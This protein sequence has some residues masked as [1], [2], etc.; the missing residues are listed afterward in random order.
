MSRII[1]TSAGG[2][3][4][5]NVVQSLKLAEPT[6]IVG[7][8][9][10][11]AMLL[12]S[13]ADEKAVVHHASEANNF[14][15]SEMNFLA[16]KHGC[17]MLIPVSDREIYITAINKK[18]L[19]PTSIPNLNIVK[20]CRNKAE[21]FK[22]M[23]QHGLPTP[24]TIA[25]FSPTHYPASLRDLNGSFWMRATVGSGGYLAHKIGNFQDIKA[26]L[27][28]YRNKK[29]EF[30]LTPYLDGQNFCWTSLW[31]DGELKLSVTK[32]RLQWVY[33]K[34]GTT[35]VQ[36]TVHNLQVS[37]LCQ[38][39]V[40]ALIDTYE[41]D[42]TGLMMADLKQDLGT[43]KI[44][45]TEIN[46]GRTGTVSLWFTLASHLIY[47]DHRVNFHHQLLRAHHKRPVLPCKKN[48][49][50]PENIMFIRHI[51]MG[52]LLMFE[53]QQIR[54]LPVPYTSKHEPFETTPIAVKEVI[55]K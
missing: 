25:P 39:T 30:M 27:H 43:G 29:R 15:I 20:L 24:F 49:S 41:P 51:D 9:V 13:G 55:G 3:A 38:D 14:Y 33:D 26:L 53:N 23:K 37:Q 11:S 22:F 54:I 19:P 47:G 6:F 31:A 45:I 35:A 46:A 10:N 40:Q 17:T 18:K 52:A 1:V 42:M 4:A 50:L 2:P 28:L 21:L 36:K 48:D 12:L 7:T 16:E 8:D 34:I 44:Y 32:E 5:E